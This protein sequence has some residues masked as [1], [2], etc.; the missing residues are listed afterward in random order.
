MAVRFDKTKLIPFND[1]L[2]DFR[3]ISLLMSN[4]INYIDVYEFEGLLD[5]KHIK[6][7]D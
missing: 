7:L 3:M 4:W 2:D 6:G 5:P 1:Y